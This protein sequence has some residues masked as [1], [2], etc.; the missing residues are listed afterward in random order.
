MPDQ[1]NAP[2][3][4][5][6]RAVF[7][8]GLEMR[9]DSE[10][11]PRILHGHFATFNSPTEINSWEGCF[12]ERLAPGAFSKTIRENRDNV[13][14]L[15]DHGYDPQLGNKPLGPIR[16]LEEDGVGCRYEVE[17]I[18]TDYNRNFIIPAAEAGLLGAS[19][20]FRVVREEWNED[21]GRSGDNPDGIPERTIKEVKLYEFG[22]V[23]FPA[24]AAATAG[25]RSKV[26]LDLWRSLDESGR[27]ELAGLLLRARDDFDG[28]ARGTELARED[29]NHIT[30]NVT[31]GVL[32][33]EDIARHVSDAL[34]KRGVENDVN[35]DT[36][37][38]EVLD[39][40]AQADAL[41]DG[42]TFETIDPDLRSDASDDTVED[43]E[44][45]AEIR[46]SD[47][48]VADPPATDDTPVVGDEGERSDDVSDAAADAT[49][50]AP[51]E[52]GHS[53]RTKTTQAD[54]RAR[55]LQLRG[56][57]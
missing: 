47:D 52:E 4:D 13:K 38:D 44:P 46:T 49:E 31:G 25:V 6:I 2:K 17:L 27:Q 5:L 9:A 53:S 23:T 3:D 7:Q 26:G 41:A 43:E 18:D 36:T 37:V 21:P 42:A 56:V 32:S 57:I 28:V 40:E 19:F 14:V 55:L 15:Y 45:E 11:G 30:V 34:V 54:R 35:A 51:A 39:L 8:P 29:R 50:D 33:A 22:P 12:I 20:R 48:E 24:Y 10:G 1:F 16:L